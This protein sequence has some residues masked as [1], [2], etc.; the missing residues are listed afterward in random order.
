M[1]KFFKRNWI[2]I[3][4][5][6]FFIIVIIRGTIITYQ[7]NRLLKYGEHSKA[8]IIEKIWNSSSYRN[9][10][11]YYYMFKVNNINY[12]GHTYDKN[13]LPGDTIEVLYLKDNPSVNRPKL[14]VFQ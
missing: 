11:G 7:N 5:S 13:Y 12:E 8:V 14:F 4:C 3:C 9:S 2:A 1:M 6:A 10:D